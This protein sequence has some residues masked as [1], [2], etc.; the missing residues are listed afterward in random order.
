[1]RPLLLALVFLAAIGCDKCNVDPLVDY[2][3]VNAECAMVEGEVVLEIPSSVCEPGRLVCQGDVVT[4]EGIRECGPEV[5]N[6]IDDDG[7]GDVDEGTD[8]PYN[9]PRDA[10]KCASQTEGGCRAVQMICVQG[11]EFCRISNGPY[12]EVCDGVDNNCKDGVDEGMDP[13]FYYPFDEYPNTIGVGVCAAGVSLCEEGAVRVIPPRLPRATDICGNG[14]DDDCDGSTDE[15][16][17]GDDVGPIAFSFVVDVSGSMNPYLEDVR[18]GGCSIARSIAAQTFYLSQ[19]SLTTYG[20]QTADDGTFRF[21]HLVQDFTD[22]ETFCGALEQY[23]RGPSGSQ[24]YQVEG[25]IEATTATWPLGMN[26]HLMLISDED[27]HTFQETEEEG[28]NRVI[29]SCTSMPFEFHAFLTPQTAFEWE[30]VL[31]TCG[32][33][34][35][36]PLNE[37]GDAV[38]LL[39]PEANE[40]QP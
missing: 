3:E 29:E 30:P 35:A 16:E 22:A 24:E 14:L 18:T 5:C 21:T 19:F 33:H 13:E 6:G 20:D 27:I 31:E 1:M 34:D 28:L 15:A 36:H 23:A 11:I 32:G 39:L 26:R 2:C 17:E 4:C 9:E 25:I 37:I 7:D 40:C 12:P 10:E 8:R 38:A